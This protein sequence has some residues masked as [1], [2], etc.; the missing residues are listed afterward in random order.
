MYVSLKKFIKRQINILPRYLDL[1]KDTSDFHKLD[2]H[3]NSASRA[4]R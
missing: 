3:Y 4:P 2:V 1:D